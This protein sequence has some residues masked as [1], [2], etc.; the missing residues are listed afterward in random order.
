MAVLTS[1]TLLSWLGRQT[2]IIEACN[3]VIDSDQLIPTPLWN[4]IRKAR[5]EAII[6]RDELLE[7]VVAPV[8]VV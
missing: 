7:L 2:A 1:V 8:E 4:S 3:S 6:L 5:T